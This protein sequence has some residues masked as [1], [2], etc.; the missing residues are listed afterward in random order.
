MAV[1]DE[2]E[3]LNEILGE[4]EAGLVVAADEGFR[5]GVKRVFTTLDIETFEGK[6]LAAKCMSN[7][8]IPNETLRTEPFFV[9]NIFIHGV[10]LTNEETGETKESRRAVLINPEGET[11]AFVSEG[12]ISS[13]Q[14]LTGLFGLPPWEPAIPVMMK[15]V[16]T[17]RGY[18]T[19]NLEIVVKAM[20]K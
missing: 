12:V 8:E 7:A 17:R 19:F 18:R 3:K 20:K 14:N 9:K 16:K 4:D 2:K 1:N 10:T 15:E 5:G 6:V 13:L 11:V